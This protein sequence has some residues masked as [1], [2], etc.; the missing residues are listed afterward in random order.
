[1]GKFTNAYRRICFCCKKPKYVTEM[2]NEFEQKN[3]VENQGWLEKLMD[4]NLS[5]QLLFMK[6]FISRK[7]LFKYFT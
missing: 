2:E 6:T 1:M 7:T 4:Y 5:Y 3:G